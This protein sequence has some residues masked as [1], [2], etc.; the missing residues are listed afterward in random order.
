MEIVLASMNVWTR[1]YG[2]AAEAGNFSIEGPCGTWSVTNGTRMS[3]K[4]SDST[5]P[6]VVPGPNVT[7]RRARLCPGGARV[8]TRSPGNVGLLPEH[9]VLARPR[10][11]PVVARSARPV[12]RYYSCTA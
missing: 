11:T 3:H 6:V 1:V 5:F 2:Y 12:E 9:S 4:I 8:S 7:E 10:R